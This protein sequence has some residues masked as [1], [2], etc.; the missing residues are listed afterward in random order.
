MNRLP[1]LIVCSIIF[2]LVSPTFAQQANPQPL[3]PPNLFDGRVTIVPDA[4]VIPTQPIIDVVQPVQQGL[5]NLCGAASGVGA[6]VAR[7]LA[8]LCTAR[9]IVNHSVDTIDGL[10]QDLSS[11]A[12]RAAGGLLDGAATAFGDALGLDTVNAGMANLRRIVTNTTGR[13]RAALDQT[14]ESLYRSSV[15]NLFARD[16]K[17][18]ASDPRNLGV[19]ARMMYPEAAV[20]AVQNEARQR[21]LLA[22][23]G[24]ATISLNGARKQAQD[25]A[26]NRSATDL[27]ALVNTPVTG[28]SA[29][30]ESRVGAAVSSREAI[31]RM[32]EGISG[33]MSVM[34][35]ANSQVAANIAA[36]ASQNVYTL[37]QLSSLVE[38]ESQK[39]LAQLE[40]AQRAAD[41][42][43]LNAWEEAQAMHAIAASASRG[44]Y[45][46]GNDAPKG[47]T[48]GP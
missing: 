34:A 3:E 10:N 22:L 14:L 35:T 7:Q 18:P 36:L 23:Q 46:I 30:L 2:S 6:G 19:L 48:V 9:D 17:R 28:L 12:N 26:T 44:F 33:V 11:Y 42:A 20:V 32:T 5:E 1:I 13:A 37:Q 15:Q 41:A 24:N 47:L 16:P 8:F 39:E 29:S 38:I 40:A 4:R 45:A 43:M 25:L 27:N 21:D 31:Q